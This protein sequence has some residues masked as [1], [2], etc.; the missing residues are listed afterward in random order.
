MSISVSTQVKFVETNLDA[1]HNLFIKNILFSTFSSSNFKSFHGVF[2][3]E[4]VNLSASVQYFSI[5]STGSTQFHRL[6]LIFL[7]ILSFT[8]QCK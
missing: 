1:F 8:N 6:L 4:R 5:I 2:Q 3:I 7:P